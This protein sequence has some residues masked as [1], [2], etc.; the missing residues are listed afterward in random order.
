MELAEQLDAYLA[1][2]N[3]QF[4]YA[5]WEPP[6]EAIPIE[7]EIAANRM[8][9]R[10]GRIERKL[11]KIDEQCDAEIS[12]INEWRAARKSGPLKALEW[13]NRSLEAFAR[14]VHAKDD[15]TKTVTVRA[16]VLRLRPTQPRMVLDDGQTEQLVAF[17]EAN[18]T[19]LVEYDPKIDKSGLKKKLEVGAP[20]GEAPDAEGFAP[21]CALLTVAGEDKPVVVPGVT[22][23]KR[24]D[25]NFTASTTDLAAVTGDGHNGETE[26]QGESE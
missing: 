18:K 22:F 24:V 12:E 5:G 23:L 7:D 13:V 21:H 20:T 15:K 19:G 16:G 10:R 25:L 4:D 1:G 17:L 11:R 14:G 8:L 2:D 3:E 9:R 26:P 6:T